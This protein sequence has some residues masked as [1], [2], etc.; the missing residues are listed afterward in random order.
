MIYR[1][2]TKCAKL[3]PP[4]ALNSEICYHLRTVS[5][6]DPMD[7]VKKAKQDIQKL[8]QIYKSELSSPLEK[9]VSEALKTQSWIKDFYQVG[10]SEFSKLS[11]D[12][13]NYRERRAEISRCYKSLIKCKNWIEAS[14]HLANDR[15]YPD[16]MTKNR[17]IS[18]VDF[19]E[20]LF[21]NVFD[22][23]H[24]QFYKMISKLLPKSLVHY[25]EDFLT[26]KALQS[27]F[28]SAQDLEKLYA[29]RAGLITNLRFLGFNVSNLKL[30]LSS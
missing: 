5:Q 8:L 7:K 1:N 14:Y 6:I 23:S 22:I 29:L 20:R 11:S 10:K 13:P 25:E 28:T 30:M 17:D 15:N 18:V 2:Q 4:L 19:F 16:W 21:A 26:Y 12:K 3:L 9:N 24:W 27:E